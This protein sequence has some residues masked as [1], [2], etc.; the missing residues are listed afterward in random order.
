MA[1]HCTPVGMSPGRIDGTDPV[2]SPMPA[3]HNAYLPGLHS[4]TGA[5]MLCALTTPLTDRTTV[6]VCVVPAGALTLVTVIRSP[7]SVLP[8]VTRMSADP[9]GGVPARQNGP[10]AVGTSTTTDVVVASM[11][12]CRVVLSESTRPRLPSASTWWTSYGRYGEQASSVTQVSGLNRSRLPSMTSSAG[13]DV[14]WLGMLRTWMRV[15]NGNAVHCSTSCRPAM[16]SRRIVS[17]GQR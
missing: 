1:F 4:R 11:A 12:A 5:E 13:S 6:S 3:P 15:P 10:A 7:A 8:M 14:T 2:Q 9:P 16:L 17:D